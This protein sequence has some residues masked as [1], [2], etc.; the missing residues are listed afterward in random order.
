MKDFENVHKSGES[1]INRSDP[2]MPWH[3]IAVQVRG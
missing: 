2:R 3:D 1:Q